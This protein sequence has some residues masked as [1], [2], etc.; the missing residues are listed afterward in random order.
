MNDFSRDRAGGSFDFTDEEPSFGDKV[1][2]LVK[3]LRYFRIFIA[4][5]NVVLI[6]CMVIFFGS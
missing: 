5:W 6:F 4:L 2:E 1:R 3:N